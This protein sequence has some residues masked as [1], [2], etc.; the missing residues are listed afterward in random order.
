MY[1]NRFT[2]VRLQIE[3]SFLQRHACDDRICLM[4][5][6]VLLY[7]GPELRT[8]SFM[9]VISILNIILPSRPGIPA[10]GR[11]G[12]LSALIGRRLVGAFPHPFGIGPKSKTVA[13]LDIDIRQV[14]VQIHQPVGEGI[15]GKAGDGGVLRE[16]VLCLHGV[17]LIV[18][19]QMQHL[20]LLCH[21]RLLAR[22]RRV[23]DQD[24]GILAG[25]HSLRR[26]VRQPDPDPDVTALRGLDLPALIPER[27]IQQHGMGGDLLIGAH[28]TVSDPGPDPGILRVLLR[29]L[30]DSQ[31]RALRDLRVLAIADRDVISVPGAGEDLGVKL[32]RIDHAVDRKPEG[33]KGHAGNGVLDGFRLHHFRFFPAEVDHPGR[34][35]GLDRLFIPVGVQQLDGD[36]HGGGRGHLCPFG[37]QNGDIEEAG[38]HDLRLGRGSR[39]ELPPVEGVGIRH[40]GTGAEELRLLRRGPGIDPV[41]FRGLRLGRFVQSLPGFLQVRI[42]CLVLDEDLFH[43]QRGAP[44]DLRLRAV[45]HRDEAGII[46]DGEDGLLRLFRESLLPLRSRLY[47]IRHG[48]GLLSGQAGSR[49]PRRFRLPGRRSLLRSARIAGYVRIAFFRLLCQGVFLIA[50]FRDGLHDG[51]GLGVLFR[52]PAAEIKGDRVVLVQVRLGL[53]LEGDVLIGLQGLCAAVL[54]KLDHRGLCS[55]IGRDVRLAGFLRLLRDAGGVLLL[56]GRGLSLTGRKGHA[57]L[58]ALRGLDCLAGFIGKR[59][60][61]RVDSHHFAFRG[62]GDAVKHSLIGNDR[63]LHGGAL[64]EGAGVGF[65]VDQ[66]LGL[67]VLVLR[68]GVIGDGIGAAAVRLAFP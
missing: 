9:F 52:A 64:R 8:V 20:D 28:G 42:I 26:F 15:G 7:K 48:T 27:D 18:L 29:D 23:V 10:R 59:Q 4:K 50:A 61:H 63:R 12:P 40:Q 19:R 58:T 49:V 25:I 47:P 17:D 24:G 54:G 51:V 65:N 31:L 53:H 60:V 66:G 11:E 43:L 22:H 32:H 30:P 14:L 57:E 68:L 21:F 56:R 34:V 67:A 1:M 36:L 46:P 35:G 38:I 62:R 3:D 13:G 39:L 2:L 6:S 5:L 41:L 16:S 44:G 37:I 45:V 33:V 55:L